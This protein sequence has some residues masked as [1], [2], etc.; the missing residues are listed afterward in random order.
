MEL[1]PARGR[2]QAIFG[3]ERFRCQK[4]GAKASSYFDI[5]DLNDPRAV[6]R[7]ERLAREKEEEENSEEGEEEVVEE[8]E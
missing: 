2:A 5:D 6:E 7:L 1:R 3:K 8:E 4:C